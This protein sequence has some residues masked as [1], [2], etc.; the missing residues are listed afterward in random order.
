MKIFVTGGTGFIG[1]H[2]IRRLKETQYELYC[3]ARVTSQVEKLEEAG[4][5][6]IRGD[7]TDKQSLLSRMRGCEWVVNLANFYEFWT[8]KRRIYHDVNI[9][10]TRNVME[11]AIET[12][13]SKIVHVSTTAVYGNAE[14]P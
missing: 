10:G 5:I 6:V 12:G 1:T 8:P 2:L 14:W 7:V 11:A 4:A 9:N 13:I 3:L